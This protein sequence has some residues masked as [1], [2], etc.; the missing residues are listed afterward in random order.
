MLFLEKC[1]GCNDDY[2]YYS[3][4]LYLVKLLICTHHY[5]HHCTRHVYVVKYFVDM[6]IYLL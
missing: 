6:L 4:V 1:K 2:K 5:Y 3:L